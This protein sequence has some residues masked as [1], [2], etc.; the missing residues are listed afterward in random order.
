VKPIG[1]AVLDDLLSSQPSEHCEVRE[2]MEP[3]GR[4]LNVLLVDD[5]L[6][7]RQL[8]LAFLRDTHHVVE[9]AEDGRV[10]VERFK[11]G[12]YDLVLMDVQMPEMD[13][14]S[15]TKAI[16][17]WER[18]EGREPTPVVAL[19]AHA[20]AEERRKSFDA[21]CDAHVSK[22]IRKQVLQRLLEGYA[23]ADPVEVKLD[24][25][26]ADLVDEFLAN[27]RTD[28]STLWTSLERCDF[29]RVQWIGHD[30]KGTGSSYGLDAISSI[31]DRLEQAAK[32]GDAD[33]MRKE[34]LALD[35][36]VNRVVRLD[37]PGAQSQRS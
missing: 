2:P 20:Y 22:P 17:A 14:Y 21:G 28:V 34:I 23:S 29:E 10:A 13:G 12:D 3:S 11:E 31:G 8:I 24:P 6:E 35:K 32:L 1:P 15:A 27:R 37:S 4:P 16:R 25:A 30:M 19:T 18:L 33:A 36:F 26:I 9:C 5:S 7:N